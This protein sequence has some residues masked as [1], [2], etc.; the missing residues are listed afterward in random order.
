MTWNGFAKY[1]C[2]LQSLCQ[3]FVDCSCMHTVP[4]VIDFPRYNMKCSGENVILHGIVHVVSGFP[5]HFM[6]YRGNLDCFS[7]SVRDCNA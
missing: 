3:H 2:N 6:L 7:N 4:K 5:P 1:I